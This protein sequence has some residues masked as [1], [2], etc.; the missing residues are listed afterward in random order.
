MDAQRRF[1]SLIQTSSSR[2]KFHQ[3]LSASSSMSITSG[4]AGS[5]VGVSPTGF[6]VQWSLGVRDSTPAELS[7]AAPGPEFGVRFSVVMNEPLGQLP[8]QALQS[9]RDRVICYAILSILPREALAEA[10]ESLVDLMWSHCQLTQSSMPLISTEKRA[11][12]TGRTY[13]R[14]TVPIGDD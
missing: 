1:T 9:L 5:F 11:A 3:A 7:L 8:I 4:L 2:D 13:E 14:A 6:T 10:R 12:R